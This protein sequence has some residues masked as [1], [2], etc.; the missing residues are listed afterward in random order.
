MIRPYAFPN[1]K[2]KHRRVSSFD[3]VE[4]R[5]GMR[6][7]AEHSRDPRIQLRVAMDHLTEDP[8]YYRKLKAA[9]L[10][11]GGGL[12]ECALTPRGVRAAAGAAVGGGLGFGAAWAI[13]Q[14]I[15]GTTTPVEELKIKGALYLGLAILGAIAV[16]STWTETPECPPLED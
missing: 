10:G 16:S 9:N 8:A 3:P 12:G 4:L 14:L 15:T 13:S 11:G 1:G 7:E 2:S 5:R 6:V